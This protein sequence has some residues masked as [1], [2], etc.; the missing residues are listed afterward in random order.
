[1]QVKG[2][3]LAEDVNL[4]DLARGTSGFSGA[5]LT[6]LVNEAA[7]HAS[8]NGRQFIELQDFQEARDKIIL[9]KQVK[10]IVRS[11]KELEMTAYHEGGHALINVLLPE[12]DPLYKVTIAWRGR[13]LGV[14]YRAPLEDK[15]SQSENDMLD[16]IKIALGGRMAEKIV[17]GKVTGGA[18]SD[19][20]NATKIARY[21]VCQLGMS[22]K[23]GLVNYDNTFNYSQ[24][25][26]DLIDSEVRRIIAECN[27]EVEKLLTNHRDKLDLIA[28][29][30]L[31][32]ETLT[33]EEVYKICNI[34]LPKGWEKHNLGAKNVF[35]PD[36]DIIVEPKPE[37]QS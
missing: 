22:D 7:I 25:T 31:E 4:V 26:A 36:N 15:Q 34:E 20:Q 6:G 10:S 18:S 3:P 19:L 24:A 17:Y 33:G 14:A 13:A 30:L 35:E 28:K 21:M 12:S 1:V 2:K 8:K 5:D 32:K 23:L 16:S 37:A 9:G 27:L 11:A 29:G